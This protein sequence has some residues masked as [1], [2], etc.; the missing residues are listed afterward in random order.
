MNELCVLIPTAIVSK[1]SER[2]EELAKVQQGKW[3]HLLQI[4]S[5]FESKPFR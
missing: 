5:A 1:S 4:S 2:T 3:E